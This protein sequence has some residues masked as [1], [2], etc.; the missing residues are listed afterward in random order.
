M[1]KQIQEL[2][3][4]QGLNLSPAQ[5]Q[6]V[7]ML[8]LTNIE[9]EARIDR[10]LI[11]NPALEE[12]PHTDET[13]EANSSDSSEDEDWDLGD[14][15]TE[16][17]I[18][19]YRLRQQQEREEREEIPFAAWSATLDD[20]LLEQ[21]GADPLSDEEVEVAGFII[22]NINADGYLTRSA[23]EI[24]DDLLFKAGL[25][26]P[27]STIVRLIERIRQLEPAGIAARDLSDCLI[28]QLERRTEGP[29]ERLA[30]TML[31]DYYDDFANKRFDRLM[32][33]LSIDRDTLAEVYALVTKLNPKP[34]ALFSTI[35]E[36]RLMH[37]YPDFIVTESGGELVVSLARER[38]I[39]PLRISAE[40]LQMLT[41]S[42]GNRQRR[43]MQAFV[44]HKVDQAR[45]FIDAIS[46]RQDTL[47]RTMQAIVNYQHAF[48]VSGEIADLRPMILKDIADRTR[49]D[50]STI[51]RVSSSKSVQTDH[52]VFPL[53]FFFGEGLTTDE[54]EEVSTKA[55]K[56]RLAQLIETEDKSAPYTDDDLAAILTDEGYRLARRTIAKYREQLRLPIAR[57]RR[58][59]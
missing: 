44:R 26:V 32:E 39:R 12:S 34:G 46:Q 1:A 24:Q 18:P 4:E 23:L 20:M 33:R 28:L 49:L 53:K 54:G 58:T 41:E 31:R 52:G 6:A 40:Y 11:E 2:K 47:L 9:L 50:I 19:E 21:L 30:L 5:I 27:E 15:V 10:E 35:E 3:Q 14:Y 56:E 38:E 45:W 57:L 29:L 55:I 59:L 42:G 37:Y 7:K 36:D 22:G 16:D 17:D 48:F 8:E 51:S 25:D 13:P 43:D